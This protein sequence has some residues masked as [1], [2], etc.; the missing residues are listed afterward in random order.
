VRGLGL[1]LA[2]A[3]V[4]EAGAQELRPTF[5][6]D[7]EG[8]QVDVLA[9]SRG[10]PLTG[11]TTDHFELRDN[12]VR[13][14]IDTV[15]QEDVPLDVFLVL[16][17]SGSVV[18]EPLAALADAARTVV[19]ALSSRDR[20]ALL[21]FGYGLTGFG[22]LSSDKELI[23]K[24]I[25]DVRPSG[26][27]ALVDAVYAA[28]AFRTTPNPSATRA[29]VIVFTDGRDTSSWLLPSA[30]LD[31]AS[32]T[33]VVVYSV[34]LTPPAPA[35]ADMV[36]PFW[37]QS[38]MP[39]IGVLPPVPERDQPPAFLEELAS[40]TGGRLLRTGS[41]NRLRDAFAQALREMKTRYVLS[42]TPQGVER[43]GWHTLDVRLTQSNAEVTARRGYFVPSGR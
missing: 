33:D 41:P 26:S 1:L 37:G 23:R 8:V 42:Y 24:A 13:Q 27:T 36:V 21:T 11:L 9:T 3:V 34:A 20:I 16:D 29:L 2:C 39:S 30:V 6:V 7:V 40:I 32:Q 31:V 28:L 19:A 15:V 10:R 25:G 12:G 18:G 4:L 5:S 43:E 38:R 35:T 14:R 22:P 17:T